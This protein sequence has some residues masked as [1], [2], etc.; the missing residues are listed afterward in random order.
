MHYEPGE[1][2]T[3]LF[4]GNSNWRGPVWL[5]TN[6]LLVQALEKYQRYL[7]DGFTLA[8]PALSA[9]SLHLRDIATLIAERLVSIFRRNETG[10]IP[11]FAPDSPHQ[12]DPYWQDLLLFHEYFHGETGQGL[13]AAHQT[14]WSALVANLVFRRYRQDIPEFWQRQ[15]VG[16]AGSRVKSWLKKWRG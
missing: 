15:R 6:Y 3:A 1:S 12:H 4:G 8:V 14:G 13:G 7:G 16:A 5:P 10:L 2:T 11:A 9:D